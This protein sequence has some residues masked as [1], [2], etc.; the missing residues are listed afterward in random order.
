MK[1]STFSR[2]DLLGATHVRIA[3]SST[4]LPVWRVNRN[5]VSVTGLWPWVS[6]VGFADV[7]DVRAVTK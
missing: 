2:D 5:T 6:R 7:T 1:Q 4:W 3:F